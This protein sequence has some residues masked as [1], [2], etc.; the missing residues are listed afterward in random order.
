MSLRE[1]L[2][3]IRQKL[4]DGVYKNEEHVR[5]SLVARV[6]LDLGWNVWDP[7][8]V[9]AEYPAVP[10]EDSTRVDIAMFSSPH[11]PDIFIEV[12]TVG[13]ISNALQK[14]ERQLRDYNR[15]N[16]A[17]FSIIT[18]G[19]FWRFYL[20]QAGGRFS[21]KCFKIVDIMKN[22]LDDIETSLR[23]FLQ[24]AEVVN[25]NAEH[26][27]QGY[28]RLTEKQRIMEGLLPQAKREVL[29]PPYPT[30][31]EALI[32]QCAKVDIAIT[33]NEAKEF[34]AK[35]PKGPIESPPDIVPGPSP[36]EGQVFD[37]DHPPDLHFTK[38]VEAKIGSRK[39]NNWNA[40]VRC[41]VGVALKNNISIT[42]LRNLDVPVEPRQKNTD[43]F[44][45]LRGM[46]VS[47]QN[48]DA[49]RA[50]HLAYTVARQLETEIRVAFRWREKDG[51]AYPGKEGLLHWKP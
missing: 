25:G 7:K 8:E 22:E 4:K 15:D 40:L 51:A 45:T 11:R 3:D 5:M 47:V 6:L 12:K 41:A 38:I 34:I 33:N 43:G 20:S 13:Q 42:E 17:L 18:D 50:W 44:S 48:V 49:R 31:P 29:K 26:E 21:D 1:T 35:S 9:N 24:K 30:L 37:P 10:H 39:E 32:A 2:S 46:N 36:P 16:T 14:V 19:R 23:M 27:A 28:L